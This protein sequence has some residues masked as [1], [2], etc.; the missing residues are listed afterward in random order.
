MQQSIDAL[1]N[2][3]YTLN[4]VRE[5]FLTEIDW[6]LRCSAQVLIT[7]PA[8]DIG[9]A[10]LMAR[11]LEQALAIPVQI[12]PLEELAQVLSQTRSGTVVTTRYF[13][14]DAEAIALPQSVRVIPLD[15][16][17]YAAEIQ[18]I[19]RLPKDSCVGIVS[20][21]SGILR[22]A[23]VIIHSLRGDDLL[24]MIAPLEDAYKLNSIVRSAQTIISDQ[25]SIAI[26]KTAV[27]AARDDI[28]RPPQLLCCENYISAASLKLL[29]RELGFD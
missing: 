15:I 21:S 17:D 22:A 8:Q 19:K 9:V 16:Y 4:Q 5:L 18:V 2:Q 26:V 3:G 28:I 27:M 10:E 1:L 25:A 24:V 6:R 11:E 13:I 29:K 7:A 20:I 14:S 23:S 12:V